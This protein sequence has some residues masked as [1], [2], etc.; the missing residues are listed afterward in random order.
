MFAVAAWLTFLGLQADAQR[1]ESPATSAEPARAADWRDP[2]WILDDA[3]S[4]RFAAAMGGPRAPQ[5]EELIARGQKYLDKVAKTWSGDLPVKR[6]VGIY[7]G[8]KWMGYM[9]LTIKAA[10]KGTGAAFEIDMVGEVKIEDKAFSGRGRTLLAKDLSPVSVEFFNDEPEVREGKELSVE[11]G[12]WKLR[13]AVNGKITETEGELKTATTWGA[14]ILPLFAIPD[15][16]V[17]RVVS[18]DSGKGPYRFAKLPRK[19]PHR[20]GAKA[21]EFRVL[22]LNKG[23]DK[24]DLC[25]Y[26]EEGGA[27]EIVPQ[28]GPARLVPIDESEMGKNLDE[29][30]AL[31]PPERAVID[32]FL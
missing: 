10:P 28:G 25:Y 29:P 24:P 11:G 15:D 32:L 30:L 1:F 3:F 13:C 27:I 9:R 31:K 6:L 21:G 18:L 14:E 7:I 19:R 8:R 22:E 17:I 26:G 4:A 16:D 12:R 20:V 23:E 2:L 5:E